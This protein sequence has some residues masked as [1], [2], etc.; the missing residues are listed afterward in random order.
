[1]SRLFIF[2]LLFSG[3]ASAPAL[4]L[5]LES[6]PRRVKS[7]HPSLKAARLAVD[8]A[9]GRQLGAG[10]LS[11]PTAGL[12]AQY[13][14]RVSPGSVTFS[15]DQ[16]FPLTR[17]LRLE[18]Q[19]TSQL[20]MA[21]EYEVM[22][23][24][25]RLIGEALEL[26]VKLL[27]L[28][29]QRAL[30]EQQTALA[31]KLSEFAA[32]R[33]EAG[34]LSALDAVQAQVDAQ[35]LLSDS[36]RIE[37]E[38]VSLKGR[39]KAMLGLAVEE[40]LTLQGNLPPLTFP[41]QASWQKRSDY[42]LA[43][44]KVVAAQTD[45]DLAHAKRWQDLSVGVFAAREKQDAEH[46]GYAGIRFS[47]P[48]PFWNRNQ[49][50]IAEKRASVERAQLE[51]K[52]LASQISHE[53]QTAH[54]EMEANAT[55]VRDTRDKLLPLMK[56]QTD[57]LEKAYEAGQTDLLTILRARDQRLELEA[58]LLDAIRDFHLARIRYEAAVGKAY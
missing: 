57:R 35:R 54:Q 11:N 42:Q 10:R 19:L 56:T 16:N 13:E 18:K 2:L 53:A 51:S 41:A 31:R 47:L 48:L 26:G 50:E 21:A 22:E 40:S 52:A 34:E 44:T 7:H 33:A 58:A 3:A 46:T 28:D 49:G 6:I 45:A 8:E 23:V 32:T 4:T 25:R 17:R 15:I 27:A 55:L 37:A 36:R 20:V 39:L 5:N 38:S 43:Q 29:K 14:S 24:Q 9:K 1:M 12:E 30:R